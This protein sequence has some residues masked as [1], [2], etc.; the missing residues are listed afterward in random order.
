MSPQINIKPAVGGIAISVMFGVLSLIVHENMDYLKIDNLGLLPMREL[1]SMLLK[2]N[3]LPFILVFVM[4]LGILAGVVF[5]IN[6][7]DGDSK[8]TK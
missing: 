8:E 1:Y 2:V 7:R 4:L 3:I 6:K 5:I